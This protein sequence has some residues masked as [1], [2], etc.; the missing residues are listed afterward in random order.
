MQNTQLPEEQREIDIADVI[1]RVRRRHERHL[2]A[3]VVDHVDHG[4]RVVPR[5]YLR[6]VLGETMPS[7]TR[8]DFEVAP[9]PLVPVTR[10]ARIRQLAGFSLR[11]WASVFGVTHT[12]IKQWLSTEP[13]REK[14]SQVTQ[15]LEEATRYHGNLATWLGRPLPGMEVTPLDLLRVDNWRAFRGALR[16]GAPPPVTISGEELQRRRQ[17][18]E[19]WAVPETP[20]LGYE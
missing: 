19:S 18:D 20:A 4:T 8:I 6:A 16:A 2:D 17:T 1:K 12:A 9:T 13:D 10:M 15:A 5:S 7:A 14:L 3:L 11:E